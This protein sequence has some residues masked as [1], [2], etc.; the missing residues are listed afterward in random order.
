MAD[1]YSSKEPDLIS[2]L[3]DEIL[4]HI[5]ENLCCCHFDNVS[6]VS[7]RF[8]ILSKDADLTEKMINVCKIKSNID[9]VMPFSRPWVN[10]EKS[11]NVI[12]STCNIMLRK[13][14]PTIHFT[15]EALDELQTKHNYELLRR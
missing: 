9:A 7:T 2:N 12:D 1:N 5:L 10:S 11:T 8:N 15:Q 13:L 3:P 14:T 6:Q 4:V